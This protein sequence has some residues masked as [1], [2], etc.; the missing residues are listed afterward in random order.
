MLNYNLFAWEILIPHRRDNKGS[1]SSLQGI[2]NVD[3]KGKK[4][5][6]TFDEHETRLVDIK[7]KILEEGYT[8]LEV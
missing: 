7:K 1:L 6:V 2:I 3:L 4:L 8:V 5:I